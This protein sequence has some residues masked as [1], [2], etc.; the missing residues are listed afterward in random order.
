MLRDG[1]I[2]VTRMTG[3]NSTTGAGGS[4]LEAFRVAEANNG[5]VKVV[6]EVD[7]K[8]VQQDSGPTYKAEDVGGRDSR[9]KEYIKAAG[10]DGRGIM[11]LD[12]DA[13]LCDKSCK[14]TLQ[15]PLY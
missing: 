8:K 13:E 3:E 7:N 2:N 6:Q 9:D 1:H 10:G 15:S 14:T 11:Q 4:N 5:R 12:R